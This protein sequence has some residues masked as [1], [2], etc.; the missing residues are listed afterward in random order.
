MANVRADKRTI[1]AG[2]IDKKC[3]AANED[4]LSRSRIHSGITFGQFN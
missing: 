2:S 3:Y 1:N 4:A